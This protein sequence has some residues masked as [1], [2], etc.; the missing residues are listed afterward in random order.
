MI[1]HSSSISKKARLGKNIFVGPFCNLAGK[2]VV[3]D[4]TKIF[5]SLNAYD[6]KIGKNCKIGTFVEV[7]NDVK[8]AD[9]C[10]V[11]SHTF[12]CEGVRLSKGVFVGH[13]VTFINDKNPRAVNS[14]GLLK[15]KYD[16][17]LVE[18]KV[19]KGASIGS[20]AVIFPVTLGKW[21]LV[22]AGS[23]VTK[24]VP[25]HGLVYGNPAQLKGLVC[26]CGEILVLSADD[27]IGKY[28]SIKCKKCKKKISVKKGLLNKLKKHK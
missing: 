28:I 4:N 10:K 19:G 25:D 2:I 20:G 24:N 3:G 9:N 26:I 18:T 13:N 15:T 16:W 1:D 27:E 17:N 7:Q 14:V 21:A 6:C 22:G 5:G 23:V 8:V 12:I 11:Q